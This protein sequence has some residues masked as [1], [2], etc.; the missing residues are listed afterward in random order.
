M[1]PAALTT[2]DVLLHHIAGLRK[3]VSDFKSDLDR[4][5][6]L[7]KEAEADLQALCAERPAMSIAPLRVVRPNEV[8]R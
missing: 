4:Y 3:Q 1:N 6:E 7:V 2:Y 5:S 8:T